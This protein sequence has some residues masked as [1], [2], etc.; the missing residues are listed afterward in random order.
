MEGDAGMRSRGRYAGRKSAAGRNVHCLVFLHIPKTAG[1]T[2]GSALRWNFRQGERIRLDTLDRPLNEELER[3]PLE[4]RSR[5][6][7]L[8]GHMPYGAHRHLP[9]RC[10]YITALRQPVARV[11]S[12][13]RYILRA[14]NHVLHDRVMAAQI[15]L[16][17]Y[18]ESG[19]D[20]GQTENSQTRQLSGRQFGDLDRAALEEA[21]RNLETFLVVGLTERFEETI[22]LA[23]RAVGLRMPLYVTRG[24]SRPF[25]VSE[26]AVELIGERNELDLELYDFARDLF[27]E[28]IAR[29]SSSFAFE[30]SMFRAW[31]PLSR[32][33]GS[34]NENARAK[35]SR[36]P[37]AERLI[38][39]LMQRRSLPGPSQTD[40]QEETDHRH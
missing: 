8:W 9:L 4:K 10:E 29:Q 22:A 25:E 1:M 13:Y 32:T 2:L 17:E 7:F 16:E 21:K 35:L 3:I 38:R 34:L 39:S 31:R 20:T 30:A 33:V 27:S 28:E 15:S 36:S 37:G 26:R 40:S 18:V 6:R 14:S 5:M 12:T 19:L 11:I 23:R 24:V